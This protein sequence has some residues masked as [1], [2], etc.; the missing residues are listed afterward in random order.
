MPTSVINDQEKNHLEARKILVIDD[1]FNIIKLMTYILKKEKYEVMTARNGQDGLK[2]VIDFNPSLIVL[3]LMMPVM[4]GFEFLE[5]FKSITG[6]DIPVIVTTAKGYTKEIEKIINSGASA[7]IEKPFDRNVF[8]ET[9]RY[10][11][12]K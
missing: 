4:N 7:Y 1:D 6:A 10:F 5:Q 12:E 9:V 2:L 3:D 11:I 8:L